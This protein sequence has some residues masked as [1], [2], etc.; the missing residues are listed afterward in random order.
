M[1]MGF[2][3]GAARYVLERA[4]LLAPS[5]DI[6]EAARASRM[7]CIDAG[8]RTCSGQIEA[9]NARFRDADAGV[10]NAAESLAQIEAAVRASPDA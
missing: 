10:K 4:E 7:E 8:L 9:M 6:S 3:D 2:F 1:L 5:R